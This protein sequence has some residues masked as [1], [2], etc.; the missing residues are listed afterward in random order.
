M[1]PTFSPLVNIF[2]TKTCLFVYI[3]HSSVNFTCFAKNWWQNSIQACSSL[4][5][6]YLN[7][8]K[9][10]IFSRLNWILLNNQFQTIQSLHLWKKTNP[11]NE[12]YLFIYFQNHSLIYWMSLVYMMGT[13]SDKNNPLNYWTTLVFS[14]CCLLEGVDFFFTPWIIFRDWVMGIW[15]RSYQ[16]ENAIGHSSSNS[17]RGCECS[18][19]T[20]GFGDRHD[21]ISPLP[22]ALWNDNCRFGFLVLV[23]Q[24][25]YGTTW[26]CKAHILLCPQLIVG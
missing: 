23:R 10:N 7:S 13:T 22:R 8:L 14:L 26:H 16:H 18:I 12:I 21:F 24:L 4:I 5:C 17:R 6:R 25:V 20:H 19:H 11:K 2:L 9:S 1:K 15:Y 3:T